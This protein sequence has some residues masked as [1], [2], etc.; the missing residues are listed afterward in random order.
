MTKTTDRTP[1]LVVA[2]ESFS[3][4]DGTT[5]IRVGERLRADDEAAVRN[6]HLFCPDGLAD[7]EFRERR[8]ALLNRTRAAQGLD[9]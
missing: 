3:A 5:A 8:L 6:P 1:E 7:W 2:L 9:A 4:P